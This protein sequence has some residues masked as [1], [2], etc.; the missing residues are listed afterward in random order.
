MAT[1]VQEAAEVEVR[2]VLEA[3]AV[4]A[5]SDDSVLYPMWSLGTHLSPSWLS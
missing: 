4:L 5:V 3:P 1:G 2:V